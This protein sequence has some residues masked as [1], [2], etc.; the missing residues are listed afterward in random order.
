MWL[1]RGFLSLEVSSLPCL[2]VIDLAK[3]EILSFQFVTWLYAITWSENH[4]TLWVSFPH[5]KL[6]LC[7]IWWSSALRKRRYFIFNL[8]RDLMWPRGHRVLW[9]Y[10]SVLLIISLHPAKFGGHKRCAGE[11]ILLFV[12]HVTSRDFVVREACD[13]IGEFPSS[14]M[15]TLQ[16]LVIIDLLEEEIL[17]FQF[18]TWLHVTTWSEGHVTS[19][20]SYPHYK[21]LPCYVW[22]S[23]ALWNRRY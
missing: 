18:V 16:S 4:L 19:W 3:G 17:T 11:E 2:K 8:S 6:P 10:G 20:V 5:H 22:W 12:C 1:H 9:H 21:S 23:Q 15:T 7:Q 13:T 14:L